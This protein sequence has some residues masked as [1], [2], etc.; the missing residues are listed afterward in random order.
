MERRKFLKAS[1]I[2]TAATT[3]AAPAIAQ[4]VR[5]WKL[6]SAWPKNLPGPGVAAQTLADRITTLSGG[7]IN[8]TLRRRRDR[9]GQRRI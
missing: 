8:V 4:D 2:G 7:R 1:A 6:V 5:N 9:P 3:L